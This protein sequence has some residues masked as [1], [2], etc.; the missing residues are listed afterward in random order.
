MY[1]LE[2]TGDIEKMR[3]SDGEL[4]TRQMLL[5]PFGIDLKIYNR[6]NDLDLDTPATKTFISIRDPI[7]LHA[8]TSF[9]A[10]LEM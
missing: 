7:I 4:P 3:L 10:S 8:R 9:I 6:T 1:I 5:E 2:S